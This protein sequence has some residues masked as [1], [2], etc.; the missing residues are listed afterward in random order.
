MTKCPWDGFF[1]E[2]FGVRLSLSFHHISYYIFVPL[3][4]CNPGNLWHSWLEQQISYTFRKE[5]VN[6]WALSSCVSYST[7]EHT[8][9]H[10]H[11]HSH[12]HVH[13]HSRA[14]AH[15]HTR[16]LTHWHTLT[17]TFTNT[18]THSH[19]HSR[20]HTRS[21]AHTRSRAHTHRHTHTHTHTHKYILTYLLHGAESFL[22]S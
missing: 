8:H 17:R 9:T 16:T 10:T 3:S 2:Y 4:L 11:A 5:S 14:R 21:H 1:S 19:A 15:T 7:C 20:T 12:T 13:T 6:V 22:R 18:L